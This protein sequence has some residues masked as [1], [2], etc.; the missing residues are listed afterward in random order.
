MSDFS[1]VLVRGDLPQAVEIDPSCH[2]AYI[3]FKK[4]KIERTVNRVDEGKVVAVDLDS[5]G[6]VVGIELIGVRQ[7]S[8]SAIRRFLP[9][10]FRQLNFER[11]NFMPATQAPCRREMQPA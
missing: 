2:S 5:S 8:I 1:S 6:N 11:A 7:F 10:Q 4:A 9:P 3:R